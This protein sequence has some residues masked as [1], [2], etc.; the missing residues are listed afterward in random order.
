MRRDILLDDNDD[1]LIEN[2]TSP[3]FAIGRYEGEENG[4]SVMAVRLPS[5]GDAS[6]DPDRVGAL[7]LNTYVKLEENFAGGNPLMAYFYFVNDRG[8]R[9]ESP[10]L[11]LISGKGQVLDRY[12][13]LAVDQQGYQVWYQR[14]VGMRYNGY[15]GAFVVG[16]FEQGDLVIDYSIPQNEKLLLLTGKGNLLEHPTR[17]VDAL[18]ELNSNIDRDTMRDKV[19]QEF[20]KDEL[21]VES[22][23]LDKQTGL[24]TIRSSE[25]YD[26]GQE[27]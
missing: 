17:G 9:Q 13:I 2:V 19:M 14:N 27:L 7:Q 15:E 20:E 16:P 4:A 3:V 11:P 10:R 12:T 8:E 1:L 18:Q 21:M 6:L 26:N 25:L 23:D 5:L 22:F 24:I